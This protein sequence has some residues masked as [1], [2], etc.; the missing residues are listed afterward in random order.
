MK[1]DRDQERIRRAQANEVIAKFH[2]DEDIRTTERK[3]EVWDR[4]DRIRRICFGPGFNFRVT[5]GYEKMIYMNDWL[6]PIQKAQICD[7]FRAYRKKVYWILTKYKMMPDT[8][9]D[10]LSLGSLIF[11]SSASSA[12]E[13]VEMEA[14]D[15]VEVDDNDG[16]SIASENGMEWQDDDF[17][18]NF[19]ANINAPPEKDEGFTE[20]IQVP[21]NSDLRFL[22]NLFYYIDD[23]LDFSDYRYHAYMKITK[24]GGLNNSVEALNKLYESEFPDPPGAHL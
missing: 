4:V 8:G 14:A 15:N 11:E 12:E 17:D 3:R 19:P 21:C 16:S 20:R 10:D 22:P 24:D 1:L 2:S 6:S 9:M 13:L 7:L 18:N 23:P 5:E